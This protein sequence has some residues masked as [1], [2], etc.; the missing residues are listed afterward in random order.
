ME[1]DN[2]DENIEVKDN[3]ED[4][5]DENVEVKSDSTA[6]TVEEIIIIEE[7]KNSGLSNI[8]SLF[9]LWY[10]DLG[11]AVCLLLVLVLVLSNLPAKRF[12]RALNKADSLYAEASYD[13]ANAKYLKAE[14][15]KADSVKGRLGHVLCMMALEDETVKDVFLNEA[16]AILS[17]ETIVDTEKDAAIEFF[18]L[19]PEILS[20]DPGKANEILVKAYS[21]LSEPLELKTALA[22]SYFNYGKSLEASSLKDAL[23]AFDEALKYSDSS[24]DM[25]AEVSL[26]STN[27]VNQLINAD[28]YS[29]A[30]VIL[31]KYSKLVSMEYDVLYNRIAQAENLFNVKCDLMLSVSEAMEPYYTLMASGF[32][33]ETVDAY[34]SPLFGALDYD[35]SRML[36]LDGSYNAETLAYSGANE[37]YIYADGGFTEDYTGVGAGLYTF[38]D[39]IVY[40]DGSM[41]QGYYFYYGEYKNGARNGY[42]ITFAKTDSTS[43][44]A[45]E[46]IWENDKPNGF[47]VEYRSDMYAYTSLAA[48]RRVTYGNWTDGLEDG[49]MTSK[50]VLN[51]HPDVFFMGTY[52]ASMGEIEALPGDPIDYK[53]VD[54]TPEGKKLIAV[55]NCST[56]GEDYFV[57]EY[58][59]QGE[60]RGVFGFTD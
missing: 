40:E 29:E 2:L 9:K 16:E 59:N 36:E 31:D 21:L 45:F 22:D 17:L 18:L 33:K 56:E 1:F 51:E 34:E 42:G 46:G 20:E 49:E 23:A 48:Y 39:V 15:I 54:E 25:A 13:K 6:E 26:A 30:Y 38:G 35:W 37:S 50:V 4:N 52:T 58:I 10:I 57:T 14:A 41:A 5:S 43:F 32:S 24:A 47:G 53:I 27:Y 11:L 60:K 44:I 3:I 28:N 8:L 19:T 12:T 55:F 7:P